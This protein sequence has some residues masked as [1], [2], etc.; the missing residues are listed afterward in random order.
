MLLPLIDWVA[1]S[2]PKQAPAHMFRSSK[3]T[4]MH[5][6]HPFRARRQTRLSACEQAASLEAS[7]AEEMGNGTLLGSTTA[8]DGTS[9]G[10]HGRGNA[11]VGS[12]QSAQ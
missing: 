2:V 8:E 6:A 5:N 4:G 7:E 11:Q 9:K 10:S 12:A 3:R 1:G